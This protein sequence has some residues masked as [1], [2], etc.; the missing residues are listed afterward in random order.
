MRERKIKEPIVSITRNRIEQ[1][2]IIEAL[3]LL[4]VNKIINEGDKVVIS[5]NWVKSK[6]AYTGT[7]V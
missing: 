6:P 1:Q 5:P 3:E 4:P 7:V 2:S